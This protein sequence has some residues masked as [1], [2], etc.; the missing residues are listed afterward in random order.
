[1]RCKVNSAHL[2]LNSPHQKLNPSH[3]DLNSA[4]WKLSPAH[5]KL[6]IAEYRLPSTHYT[7]LHSATD[8]SLLSEDIF[9]RKVS[10]MEPC[11]PLPLISGFTA[12]HWHHGSTRV[13]TIY[14]QHRKINGTTKI[15]SKQEGHVTCGMWLLTC[16]RWNVTRDR[17]HMTGD[18][19]QV[20]HAIW[21]MVW[22]EHSLKISA[23]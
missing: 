18:T 15:P 12:S 8:C 17:W 1:M 5:W 7:L 11:P 23:N 2:K 14:E 4:H 20:T 3:W 10:S 13:T 9:L 21:H 22:D 6:D 16:D 19:W